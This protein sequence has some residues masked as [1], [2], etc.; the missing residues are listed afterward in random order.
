MT[1]S[2]YQRTADWLFAAGKQQGN[3]EH[4]SV[5]VGVDAEEFSEWLS[6]LRVN[7]DGWAKVLERIRQDLSDLA[8]AI[9]VGKIVAHVPQHERVNALDALCDRE[10][11]AN[12]CAWL[13]GFDKEGADAEVLQSNDS[14]L[15]DGKAVILPGGK[16]GKGRF[17][18]KADLKGLI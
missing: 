4:I 5:Q 15:E 2:N 17:Y 8:N 7:Q 6:C 3:T 12:G 13:L 9:K 10:V 16:I 11:T 1:K 18:K 14:K